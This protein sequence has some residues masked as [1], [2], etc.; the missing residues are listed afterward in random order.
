MH[1]IDMH[2]CVQLRENTQISRDAVLVNG[3][4]WLNCKARFAGAVRADYLQRVKN[5]GVEKCAI[6]QQD[7]RVPLH[8]LHPL[9]GKPRDPSVLFLLPEMARDK[10]AQRGQDQHEFHATEC[11]MLVVS[12]TVSNKRSSWQDFDKLE[13]ILKDY[14]EFLKASDSIDMSLPLHAHLAGFDEEGLKIAVLVS[15]HFHIIHMQH[16]CIVLEDVV[17]IGIHAAIAEEVY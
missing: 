3:S 11:F 1:A 2:A 9:H 4:M 6:L 5:S 10:E 8:S 15:T 12:C 17:S 14:K 16:C 7:A 13:G